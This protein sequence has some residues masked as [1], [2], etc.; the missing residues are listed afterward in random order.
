VRGR[1]LAIAL[2]V[3][4]LLFGA[5]RA[6]AWPVDAVFDVDVGDDRFEKL[7]QLD[8][9]TNSDPS[10]AEVEVLPSGELDFIGKKPGRTLLLLS[11]NGKLHAFRIRVSQKG[12]RGLV[13]TGHPELVA[14]AKKAC[15]GLKT[16]GSALEASIVTDGCRKALRTL[17]Q[18]SDEFLSA[19][20]SL[21]FDVTQL[22]AQLRDIET[23]LAAKKSPAKAHYFG[24]GLVL[25]G[26]LTP[27]QLH[28]TLSQIY[29]RTVGRVA[30]DDQT[31]TA[32]PPDSG[33]PTP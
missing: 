16:E 8:W 33:A 29:D 22:Q 17:F 20:I 6:H 27:T 4:P 3:L 13:P 1:G 23:G 24:A 12:M 28:E 21:T 30:L 9:L 5:G 2:A 7:F 31:H 11:S 18:E 14:A 25:K 10:V 15:P 19:D 32:P 26:E